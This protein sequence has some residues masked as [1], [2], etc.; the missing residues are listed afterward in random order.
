MASPTS[1]ARKRSNPNLWILQVFEVNLSNW[2]GIIHIEPR[3]NKNSYF[4]LYWLVNRDPYNLVG[5]FKPS[6]KY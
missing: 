1:K 6:E 4:P 3:K 5:G 2:E